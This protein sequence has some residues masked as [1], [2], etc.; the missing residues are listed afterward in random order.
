M[1]VHYEYGIRYPD[2]TPAQTL[3]PFPTEEGARRWVAENPERILTRR[4]AG[5]DDT[6][7]DA[8]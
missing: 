6:W 3:G 8:P 2:Q 4:P 7:R 1:T 5:T